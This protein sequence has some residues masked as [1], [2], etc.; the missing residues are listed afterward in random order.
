MISIERA[1]EYPR[2]IF[3]NAFTIQYILYSY[4]SIALFRLFRCDPR[5]IAE[6]SPY[7][8][9]PSNNPFLILNNDALDARER[10]SLA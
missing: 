2:A 9:L 4:S 3:S 10:Q 1:G 7:R 8:N 5:P 6:E